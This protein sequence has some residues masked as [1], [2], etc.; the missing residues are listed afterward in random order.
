[1]GQLAVAPSVHLVVVK[2][3]VER[4]HYE[5]PLI[6][7]LQRRIRNPKTAIVPHVARHPGFSLAA[8]PDVDEAESADRLAELSG[9][10][11]TS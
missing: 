10:M 3:L 11:I 6:K 9:R 7:P 1:M 5:H 2:R 8:E 4:R